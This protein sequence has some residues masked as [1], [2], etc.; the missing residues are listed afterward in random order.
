MQINCDQ[1]SGWLCSVG[2]SA[3]FAPSGSD[4]G[5]QLEIASLNE[6]VET[7]LNTRTQDIHLFFWGGPACGLGAV[8]LEQ[9]LDDSSA[10]SECVSSCPP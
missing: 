4:A 6:H 1:R 9:L 3:C 10:G 8:H 7:R 5:F 2:P